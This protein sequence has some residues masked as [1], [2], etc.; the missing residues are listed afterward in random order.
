MNEEL[1]FKILAKV[2]FNSGFAYVLENDIKYTYY[3]VD[4][5]I[6]GTDGLF[7]ICYRFENSIGRHKAFG[8]RK[9]DLTLN[10]GEVV[11][12]E[13]QWWDG[14]Y[15]KLEQILGIKFGNI[16]YN[17]KENLLKC[18]VYYGA[19]VDINVINKI[20]ELFPDLPYYPYHDY[21]KVIKYDK[22]FSD[23]FKVTRKLN[24]DKQVLISHVKRISK[25]L[26]NETI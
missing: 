3:K 13:G 14:G 26:K 19:S 21:D 10:T 24:K 20:D 18:Y 23:K 1:K 7:Y 4:D 5:I 6:Y 22:L 8:G 9:F 2:K 16:T 25:Q 17:T 12:C 15:G 11:K